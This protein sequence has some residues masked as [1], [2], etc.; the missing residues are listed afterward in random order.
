METN[1]LWGEILPKET[2]S[3]RS[4]LKEQ[5]AILFRI[6]N[7]KLRGE[8]RTSSCSIFDKPFFAHL[9]SHDNNYIIHS[10]YVNAPSI[11]YSFELLKVIHSLVLIYPLAVKNS[12][13]DEEFQCVDEK[14]FIATLESIMQH[15]TNRKV[16]QNLLIQSDR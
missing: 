4:I 6:T 11:N 16:I 15:E 12:S 8:V 2:N 13:T 9:S 1:G 7:G 3:P 5:A 14:E 10:L